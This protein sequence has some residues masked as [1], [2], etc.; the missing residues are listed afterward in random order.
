MPAGG[1]EDTQ[2]LPSINSWNSAVMEGGVYFV[3]RTGHRFAIE[4][5]NFAPAK[6]RS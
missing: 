4:F 1:G 2:V 3:T 6:R 5:L